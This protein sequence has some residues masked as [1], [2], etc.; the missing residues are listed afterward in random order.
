MRSVQEYEK[1]FKRWAPGSLVRMYEGSAVQ[2]KQQL[3]SAHERG[4]TMD[5]SKA[6]GLTVQRLA[7]NAR[8]S[9]LVV[10]CHA[11]RCMSASIKAARESTAQAFAG[12]AAHAAATVHRAL[13][14][15]TAACRSGAQRPFSC[16]RFPTVSC[17]PQ[18][19]IEPKTAG[20]LQQ[21]QEDWHEVHQAALDRARCAA[22]TRVGI[23]LMRCS[24][25]K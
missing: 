9:A 16:D 23:G 24:A 2:T 5:V 7:P 21:S 10:L 19:M 1:K 25:C 18:D 20:L 6:T 11:A 8:R 12:R 17:A 4:F 15:R 22:C 13:K 3:D 14:P